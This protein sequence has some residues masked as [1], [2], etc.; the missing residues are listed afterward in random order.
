MRK[1]AFAIA[2]AQRPD[3]WNVGFEPI[4]HDDVSAFVACDT[5]R[6]ESQIVRIRLA[7]DGEE[8]MRALDRRTAFAAIDMS[9][10]HA[11]PSTD[12]NAPGVQTEGD[13]FSGEDVLNRRRDVSVLAGDETGPRLDDRHLG[14]ESPE[15]LAEF[16]AD[17]AAADDHEVLRQDVSS[18]IIEL[19][20]RNGTPSSPG[21]DGIAARAPTF[22]KMRSALSV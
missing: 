8:Q 1:R 20:V 11:C 3:A 15:H 13:T 5:C 7:A 9:G 17:V 16:Q 6:F 2:L 4:V 12:A 10:H 19:F 14:P 18:V 22:R 21:I